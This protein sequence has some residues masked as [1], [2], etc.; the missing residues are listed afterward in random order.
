MDLLLAALPAAGRPLCPP[1]SG[2]SRRAANLSR[3]VAAAVL[4]LEPGE[5]DPV[6]IILA[7]QLRLRR[8][9][10]GWR[11]AASR[12]QVAEMHRI[13]AARDQLIWHAIGRVRARIGCR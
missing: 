4:G 13:A 7:A 1:L 9:R 5:A 12:D 3:Q 11:P 8:Y 10:R 6:R 2:P